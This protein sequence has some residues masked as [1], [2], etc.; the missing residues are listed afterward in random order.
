MFLLDSLGGVSAECYF[1]VAKKLQK[2]I[3]TPNQKRKKEKKKD[4]PA[5][6]KSSHNLMKIKIGICSGAALPYHCT[7]S[8]R[9][10]KWHSDLPE[11]LQLT[12]YSL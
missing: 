8:K 12:S 9:I 11:P 4:N 5:S 3:R 1:G 2:N 6:S 10:N 7:H